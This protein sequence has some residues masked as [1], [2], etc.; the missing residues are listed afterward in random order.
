MKNVLIAGAAGLVGSALLRQLLQVKELEKII[1]FVRRPLDFKH[2]V[3]HQVVVDFDQLDSA[4]EW[5]TGIDTV[6]CCL[7][8]T[9]KKAGTKQAF[10]KVDY[11]YPLVMARLSAVH[12]VKTFCCITAMGADPHS[13]IFYNQVKG[14]V[15]RDIS[16]LKI[17]SI[18]F[19]R[20]SL[21][22]GNRMEKRTGEKIGIVVFKALDFLFVGPLK[23]YKGIRIEKVAQAMIQTAS[24][25]QHGKHIVLSGEMQ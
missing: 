14:E 24:H 1:V 17:S 12:G 8:T 21:L 20:P 13:S 3:V 25:P 22:I 23:N 15:E 16:E 2:P 10:R 6:F 7:G 19:F 4:Q 9:I 5:F 11:E 18:N